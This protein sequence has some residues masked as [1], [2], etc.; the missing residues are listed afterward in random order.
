MEPSA[1]SQLRRS[2]DILE[3]WLV[4][5]D[6]FSIQECRW[7]FANPACGLRFYATP[8][9]CPSEFSYRRTRTPPL[10]V[11]AVGSRL[12]LPPTLRVSGW[13]SYNDLDDSYDLVNPSL[14]IR[15]RLSLSQW[16]STR[17]GFW[18]DA[19]YMHRDWQTLPRVPANLM[20][21]QPK[22]YVQNP[23]ICS[24]ASATLDGY[25]YV[26]GGY[27]SIKREGGISCFKSVRRLKLA[28]FDNPSPK[29]WEHITN[30]HQ[31]RGGAVGFVLN[32]SFCVVGGFATS[33]DGRTVR[34]VNS[35][36]MWD[37]T[38]KE[39]TLV[40]ELWPAH[41]FGAASNDYVKPKV[42]VV[43]GQLYALRHEEILCYEAGTKSWMSLGCIP[44]KRLV[45][46][47]DLSQCK[48]LMAAGDELWV[49][50]Y[51]KPRGATPFRVTTPMRTIIFTASVNKQNST[52]A[53]SLCWK[54]LPN[55]HVDGDN[56]EFLN[57]VIRI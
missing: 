50:H 51:H 12:V 39:W 20:L 35:G 42:A 2:L 28:D 52:S 9:L 11:I 53:T 3:P 29:A 8:P 33:R 32:G 19:L 10:D 6:S 36:E 21:Q 37:P 34:N 57:F 24:F 49:V 4:Y 15:T 46:R 22:A 56:V 14:F 38:S 48:N 44:I 54:V 17:R 41:I 16:Q 45:G 30:M 40:S 27:V 23:F 26:A 1:M 31:R 55:F 7:S 43:N 13:W 5:V 47:Q 25:V 18:F